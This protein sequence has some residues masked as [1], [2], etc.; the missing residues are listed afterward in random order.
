M[1]MG[2]IF[3][4][5]LSRTGTSSLNEALT[6]LGYNSLHFPSI[7]RNIA[8][9]IYTLTDLEPFDALTDTPIVPIFP[10]LDKAYPNGKFI[11]TIRDKNDWLNS[12]ES[13]FKHKDRKE[14]GTE[15]ERESNF[16]RL[17]TYGCL[18]F[19]RER[20]SY[21]FDRHKNYVLDYFKD[22]VDDLLVI[23]ICSDPSW[24]EL[25]RFLGKNV[26][27]VN[28]PHKNSLPYRISNNSHRRG[29]AL[30]T[31]TDKNFL[32]GTEVLLSSFLKNNKWFDGD[33]IVIEDDLTN[34]DKERLNKICNVIFASPRSELL[35]R[36]KSIKE[37]FPSLENVTRRFYTI[38]AFKFNEYK[39]VVFIDSDILCTADISYLFHSDF[40][41]AAAP[42]SCFYYE[43][44]RNSKTYKQIKRG[45][46]RSYGNG[47]S[48]TFNSGV[49]SF[50]FDK[51]PKNTYEELLSKI[52]IKTWDGIE[53]PKLADQ[54]ILNFHFN[55]KTTYLTSKFNY[56][57]FLEDLIEK[58]E[59]I[60]FSKASLIHFAGVFKPWEKISFVELTRENPS[61]LK[62]Y[63]AWM[64]YHDK[65]ESKTNT[66]WD[67]TKESFNN[68][69]FISEDLN[70]YNMEAKELKRRRKECKISGKR[71]AHKL[72]IEESELR[73]IEAGH[74]EVPID[75]AKLAVRKLSQFPNQSNS[76][77]LN[78]NIPDDEL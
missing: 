68:S 11:L 3:G 16:H 50:S 58:K 19:N 30:I 59:D 54:I 5:G 48:D 47:V 40:Y 56:V 67:Q 77:E 66:F 23:D 22:R 69:S 73:S 76:L 26:P 63:E 14:K 24:F 46:Q 49:M 62:F 28:F 71:L 8:K 39:N 15:L 9:G 35:A 60:G 1:F 34:D 4:I 74:N 20:F 21:V 41:F 78:M 36:V 33:I 42:D 31:V 27:H 57:V 45:K 6:I 55:G 10:Q 37:K 18:G 43:T 51:I 7:E 13:F 25:T 61:Y 72:E 64:K 12:C 65:I 29:S 38:E 2:K 44:T 70:Y 52:D 53:V 75:I 17:F 32:V